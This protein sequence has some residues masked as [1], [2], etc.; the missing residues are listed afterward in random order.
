MTKTALIL[1][2]SASLAACAVGPNYSRP[3]API[4]PTFKE[5]PAGWTEA[6]P[7]DTLARGEWWTLFGDAT[8]N[9]LAARVQVSNQNI[10]AAEAAYR[11]ARAS[12]AEARSDLFPT[13]S[14]SG[15]ATRSG[16]G[17]T[18]NTIVNSDGS[19]TTTGGGRRSTTYRANLGGSWELD[20]WGRIRRTLE[21]ARANAQASEA[22][23][24]AAR[25]AAQ[26]ELAVNYFG[27]RAADVELALDAATVEGYRRALEIAENQYKAGIAPRSDVLQAKTQFDSATADMA[28]T[29]QVRQTYEH[30][31]AV[32]VG[33]APGNFTLSA[34][35]NWTPTVPEIPAGIPSTLLQ[36]RPDIAA[37]ERRMAAANAQVGIQA[38]AFFPALTLSGSYGFAGSS[39]GSLFNAP[40]AIWSYGAAAAGT[41]LDFGGRA[42][43]VRG[44][45]A[46]Y[47]QTVAQ[48]RQTVLTALQDVEDQLIATTVLNQQLALRRDASA[49][50]NTAETMVLNRYR[51]GQV[52]YVEV[53]TAQTSAYAARRTL[54]QTTS[55]RLSAAVALIQALGGGWDA[56]SPQ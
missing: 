52:S 43:A 15:G 38:S 44:A 53:V 49:A 33:E 47:D 18:S 13:V 29:R 17:G 1:L 41:L 23:L 28:G 37:A 7:A 12:V 6:T 48:Y 50:A 4:S 10:A 5:A 11:Q 24:A 46:G 31:I 51:L 2:A 32:L 39:L 26:G 3:S 56:G 9:D 27:L 20:V 14:I 22:D 19:V 40:N 21:N 55:Q 36:R 42:A 35:D 25:L 34:V 8:L 54:I 16:S 45:K 30:A